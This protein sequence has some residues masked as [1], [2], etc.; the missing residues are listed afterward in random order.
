ML[1]TMWRLDCRGSQVE[2]GGP[3]SSTEDFSREMPHLGIHVVWCGKDSGEGKVN[4]FGRDICI[5]FNELSWG[6]IE[7]N[8]AYP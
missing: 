6:G 7:K 3:F 2:S 4:G 8:Q 1:A 5:I